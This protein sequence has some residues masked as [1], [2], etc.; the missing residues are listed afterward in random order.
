MVAVIISGRQAREW[1]VP[2]GIGE[3]SIAR[4]FGR[5]NSALSG[6]LPLGGAATSAA[7]DAHGVVAGEM[8]VYGLHVYP[9]LHHRSSEQV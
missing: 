1:H 9:G 4:R 8:Y 3:F 7:R 6:P 5:E 2:L